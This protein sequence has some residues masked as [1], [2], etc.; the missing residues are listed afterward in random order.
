MPIWIRHDQMSAKCP[1]MFNPLEPGTKKGFALK[2]ILQLEM[3]YAINKQ[4]I[5]TI[6]VFKK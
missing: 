6:K 1:G 2:M 3:L 4:E 5:A